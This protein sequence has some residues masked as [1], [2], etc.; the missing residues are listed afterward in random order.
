MIFVSQCVVC[1]DICVSVD[2]MLCFYLCIV[3]IQDG[4]FGLVFG[5][6]IWVGI[7]FW[8]QFVV[9]DVEVCRIIIEVSC[10]C[11]LVFVVFGWVDYSV[12]CDYCYCVSLFEV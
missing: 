6:E 2:D 10:L 8:Q 11:G 9:F 5:G 4:D 12:V 7:V 1:G 3:V